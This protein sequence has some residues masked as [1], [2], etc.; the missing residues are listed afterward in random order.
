MT[1]LDSNIQLSTNCGQLKML[2][3]D[4]KMRLTDVDLGEI[5]AISNDKDHKHLLVGKEGW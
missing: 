3:R 5:A 4:D 1:S 2:V